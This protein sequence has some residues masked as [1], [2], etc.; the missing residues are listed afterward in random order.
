MRGK[1]ARAGVC[2]AVALLG[3]LALGCDKDYR[4]IVVVDGGNAEL[5]TWGRAPKRPQ[6]MWVRG[7]TVVFRTDSEAPGA[8]KK[9]VGKAGRVYRLNDN[10]ELEEVG[11]F[12]LTMPNDTLAYQFGK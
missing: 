9:A 6:K 5:V 7:R 2:V 1:S 12:A 10:L 8:P 4:Q 3:I 11:E